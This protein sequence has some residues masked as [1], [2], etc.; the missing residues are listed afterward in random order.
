[1][2]RAV[3]GAEWTHLAGDPRQVPCDWDACSDFLGSV[4]LSEVWSD[5]RSLVIERVCK[6]Q[7]FVLPSELCKS[8]HWHRRHQMHQFGSLHI[9]EWLRGATP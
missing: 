1:M 6:R 7:S 9:E 8:G 4:R 2:T 3:D 5:G